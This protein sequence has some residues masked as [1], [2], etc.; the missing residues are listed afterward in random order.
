MTSPNVTAQTVIASADLALTKTHVTEYTPPLQ[1]EDNVIPGTQ[2][3]WEVNVTNNGPDK[4]VGPY[5]VVDTLP[6]G[7]TYVSSQGTDWTCVQDSMN[8]QKITCTHPNVSPDGLAKDGALPYLF[9][10]VSVDID[11]PQT[12]ENSATVTG[13]TY[14]PNLDNN[15]G[16][17]TVTPLAPS[18]QIEKF[19]SDELAYINQP[20]SWRLEITN[21][22]DN[23]PGPTAYQISA[24]DVLPPNWT[25]KA[26]ST[27][28]TYDGSEIPT[29]EPTVDSTRTRWP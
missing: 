17:D 9:H 14:D 20:Y 27:V 10:T 23:V 26:G 8:L 11:A 29:V 16:K 21:P 25:Y 19:N 5:V 1:D 7:N 22:S 2:F 24:N 3:K 12:M 15:T 13:K 6:I 28:I 4:A 18:V